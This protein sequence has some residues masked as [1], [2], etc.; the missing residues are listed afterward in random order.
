L[1]ELHLRGLISRVQ[2]DAMP[3]KVE[4]DLTELGRSLVPVLESIVEWGLT[5]IHEQILGVD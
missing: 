1:K 5:G 4:Y 3:L 2:Y